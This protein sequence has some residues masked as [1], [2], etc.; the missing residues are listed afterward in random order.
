MFRFCNIACFP[1]SPQKEIKPPSCSSS[2]VWPF[3]I[4]HILHKFHESGRLQF[5]CHRFHRTYRKSSWLVLLVF[6]HSHKHN[7]PLY[8]MMVEGWR[9]DLGG[10]F[11]HF[12]QPRFLPH[13]LLPKYNAFQDPQNARTL[14]RTPYS[15][16][17]FWSFKPT[18]WKFHLLCFTIA[19]RKSHLSD[20]LFAFVLSAHY[21]VFVFAHDISPIPSRL[22]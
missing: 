6:R 3:R 5:R 15:E 22:R 10:H 17:W 7:L 9:W 11:W 19:Y 12:R 13:D 20:T 16:K 21:P 18:L 2:H 1:S 14:R 4:S 8:H